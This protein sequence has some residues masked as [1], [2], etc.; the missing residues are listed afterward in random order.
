MRS[1]STWIKMGTL[2]P[3]EFVQGAGFDTLILVVF[4]VISLGRCGSGQGLRSAI[5]ARSLPVPAR[6]CHK[7]YSF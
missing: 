6:C 7:P 3:L 1:A 2:L 5:A 4:A